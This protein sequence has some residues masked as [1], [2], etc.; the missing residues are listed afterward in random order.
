M[1]VEELEGVVKSEEIWKQ[2]KR[3]DC[4]CGVWYVLIIKIMIKNNAN[5]KNIRHEFMSNVFWFIHISPS[6]YK[7]KYEFIY[8]ITMNY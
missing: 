7:Y 2:E 1:C 4:C 5:F 3:S 8:Y 6:I